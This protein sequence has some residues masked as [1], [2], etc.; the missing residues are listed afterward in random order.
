M[1]C[2]YKIDTFLY[3]LHRFGPSRRYC[4]SSTRS[5]SGTKSPLPLPE[6]TVSPTS[7]IPFVVCNHDFIF[8]NASKFHAACNFFGQLIRLISH[9]FLQFVTALV[10]VGGLVF[11]IHNNDEKRAVPKGDLTVTCID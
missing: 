9:L 1:S 10:G 7:R 3:H 5:T 11:F 6:Q 2:D 4:S 8:I